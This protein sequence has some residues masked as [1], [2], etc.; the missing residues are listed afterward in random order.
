MSNTPN[1]LVIQKVGEGET[2][3]LT[4]AQYDL[5]SIGADG[6]ATKI[7]NTT[8][9]LQ[10]MWKWDSNT[11]T[12]EAVRLNSGTY[13]LVETRSPYGYVIADPME[14]T[15][16]Q[17]GNVKLIKGNGRVETKLEVGAPVL[18]AEDMKTLF[19]FNKAE[20]FNE[21]C[22]EHA[23]DTRIL[24]GVTF[25][26]Y[27]DAA[28]TKVIGTAVSDEEGVVTFVGLPLKDYKREGT[29]TPVYIR[30]TATVAGHV[31]DENVYKVYVESG[32]NENG[33]VE[34]YSTLV[35]GKEELADNTVINDVYRADFT[36]SKVSELNNLQVIPGAEYGL[37]KTV[38]FSA[39]PIKVDYQILVAKAVSDE[40]GV[41][42]FPGL[43][44][45]TE[46]TVKELSVPSGSYVSENSISFK[47]TWNNCARLIVLDH[48][49][50]TLTAGA[51]GLLWQEPQV[52]V[53]ILKVNSAKQGLAGAT[54][55][56]RDKNGKIVPVLDQNGKLVDAWVSTTKAHTVSGILTA[57]ESYYLYELKAPNGY[58]TSRRQRFT[59]PSDAME[60]GENHVI[61]VV[62]VNYLYEEAPKTGD[63]IMAAVSVMTVSA[64]ELIVLLLLKKKKK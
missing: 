39:G 25:T 49:D 5:Y 63:D 3:L 18:V 50:G 55:Q 34:S 56:I 7:T 24:P 46:Y 43:L 13:C 54:L 20:L 37:Y 1:R 35:L 15:M 64:A 14:F 16:D 31:L 51:N 17:Q 44:M 23:M 41:V 48:G 27:E 28:L 47:Y 30:E 53:S 40:N 32:L 57:G 59:V 38:Q 26:A 36:F 58:V 9:P 33:Q 21:Y 8:D 61:K 6:K 45:D 52:V 42:I 29:S 4:G 62:M 2:E 22:Y 11:G 10:P 60:P 12:G 19:Q